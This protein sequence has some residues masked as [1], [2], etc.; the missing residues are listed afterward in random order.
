M[1]GVVG[2]IV[3]VLGA[4]IALFNIHEY[5]IDGLFVL[6]VSMVIAGLLMR[7]EQAVRDRDG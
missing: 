2:T 3:A 7:I 5:R 6:G 4:L 1:V